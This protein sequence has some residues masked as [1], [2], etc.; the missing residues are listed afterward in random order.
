MTVERLQTMRRERLYQ[1]DHW[2]RKGVT[3]TYTPDGI[4]EVM[5]LAAEDVAIPP[6]E[7]RTEAGTGKDGTPQG[8]DGTC[9]EP[10]AV[11]LKIVRTY[12]NPTW[13]RCIHP[14]GSKIDCRV[15]NNRHLHALMTLKGCWRGGDGKWVYPGRCVL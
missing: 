10:A 6:K 14:D 11:D 12:P 15:Q 1:G 7:T 5:R 9:G 13:V 2:I 4:A 3:V 8:V